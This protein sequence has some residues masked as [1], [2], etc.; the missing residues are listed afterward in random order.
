MLLSRNSRNKNIAW[1]YEVRYLY[2]GNIKETLYSKHFMRIW[3]NNKY[4][5]M[6]KTGIIYISLVLNMILKEEI[7]FEINFYLYFILFI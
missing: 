1:I 4:K 5:I 2:L 3:R 7:E 6:V